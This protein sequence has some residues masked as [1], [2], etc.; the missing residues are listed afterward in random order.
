VRSA[1]SVPLAR[2]R[3]F[4]LFTDEMGSWWPLEGHSVNETEATGVVVEPRVGGRVYETLAGGGEADW[5]LVTAW[6]AGSRFGMTW[7]PGQSPELA[8][9][10]VVTFTDTDD[11]GTL[12]ELVHSGW[13]ARGAEAMRVRSGYEEGWPFVLGRF[14]ESVRR[15]PA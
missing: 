10:L 1:V 14:A 3:A 9:Q 8:T 15:P 12:V 7:H 2:R 11:G 6:D 4:R 5:G 13:E